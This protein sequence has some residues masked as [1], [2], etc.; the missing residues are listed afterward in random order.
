MSNDE[1]MEIVN[2]KSNNDGLSKRLVDAAMKKRSYGLDN[3][4]LIVIDL[5]KLYNKY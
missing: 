4:S 3:I 1:V 2:D 5:P